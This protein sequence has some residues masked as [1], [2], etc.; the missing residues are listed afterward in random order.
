MKKPLLLVLW[1]LLSS[2][3]AHWEWD[4]D[5]DVVQN[6]NHSSTLSGC[7]CFEL[8][9]PHHDSLQ[10]NMAQPL[11]SSSLDQAIS[12]ASNLCADMLLLPPL[13]PVAAEM[14]QN[15]SVAWCWHCPLQQSWGRW[16][17]AH[18]WD[19]ALPCCCCSSSMLLLQQLDES[20]PFR[21]C[22]PLLLLL[23]LQSALL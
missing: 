1:L 4:A 23:C 12:E 13:L 22:H 2:W 17:W 10:S 6:P 3:V 19:K 8:H 7:C 5:D 9:P 20:F 14:M 16:S 11:P 21:K 15:P 18:G